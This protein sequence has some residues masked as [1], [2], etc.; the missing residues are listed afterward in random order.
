M[1]V[2]LAAYVT[3]YRKPYTQKMILYYYVLNIIDVRTYVRTDVPTKGVKLMTTHRSGPGGSI[4][5]ITGCVPSNS[6]V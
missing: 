4:S 5:F 6:P 3:I 2:F 1:M